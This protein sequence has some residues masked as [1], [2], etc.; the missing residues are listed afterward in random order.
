MTT[1]PNIVV[2]DLDS[3]CSGTPDDVPAK[4]PSPT[5]GAL[6]FPGLPWATNYTV[7]V[8]NANKSSP[9]SGTATNV[10]NS[11][12]TTGNPDVN[13]IVGLTD[14]PHHPGA[15]STKP[16][17]LIARL[18][19]ERGFTLV[20][21]MVALAIGL[22]VSSATL[23]IVIVSVHLSSNYTDRVDANQ[24]GRLAMEK[25]T[26]ALDSSCV[27]PNQAPVLAGSTSTTLN[28]YSTAT[29]LPG[30]VPNEIT[31]SLPVSAIESVR[32]VHDGHDGAHRHAPELGVQS[33][34]RR[35]SSFTLAQWAAESGPVNSP[36]P[37]F[38]YFPYT[39]NG[40][41]STTAVTLTNGVLSAAQAAATA[42]VA[43]SY[44]VWPSDNWSANGRP[45][46]FSDAVTFRLTAPSSSANASNLPCM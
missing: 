6:Q 44:Q 24:Q 29:D 17:L 7:C 9:L 10:D 16:E 23:A 42:E 34:L 11:S 26:Q 3:G 18:R 46:D 33:C 8:D 5:T 38:Q 32:S 37:V 27:T 36:T 4:I 28:F 14:Q 31:I 43:I 39:S 22:V 41:I 40:T 20:E 25:I 15:M 35:S 19:D 45:V 1:K 2:W 13:G 21:V 30:T 12:Y